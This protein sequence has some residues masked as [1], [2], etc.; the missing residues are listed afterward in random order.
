[1]DLIDLARTFGTLVLVLSLLIL[2]VWGIRRFR[3][4][5]GR[6][7][8]RGDMEPDVSVVLRVPVDPKHMLVMVRRDFFDHLI[9]IGPNS[10][11][12]VEQ[13]ILVGHKE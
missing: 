9:L 2:A 6:G 4:F 1:L 13:N 3:L 10:M 5:Q 11:L 8:G 12:L 7:F